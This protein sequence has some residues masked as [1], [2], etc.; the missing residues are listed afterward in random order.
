M[1]PGNKKVAGE[2]LCDAL[3]PPQAVP[4]VTRI[5]TVATHKRF[6]LKL[7]PAVYRVA[8]TLSNH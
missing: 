3:I 4:K 2:T 1:K 8:E 7:I 6:R 5:E